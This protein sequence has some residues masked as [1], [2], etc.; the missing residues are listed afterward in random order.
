MQFPPADI[1]S[2]HAVATAL[3]AVAGQSSEGLVLVGSGFD[4]DIWRTGRHTLRL[5]RRT[6]AVALIDNEHRWQ[7]EATAPLR[8]PTPTIVWRGRP[9]ELFPHPWTVTTW[10]DGE[11]ALRTGPITSVDAA[12]VLGEALSDLHRV[13]PHDAPMNPFRGVPLERRTDAF[14][15]NNQRDGDGW[16]LRHFDHARRAPAFSGQPRWLHGDIHGG[17]LLVRDGELTGLIDFGDLC[18]GD[19]ACDLGGALLALHPSTWDVFTTTYRADGPTWQ[20]AFGWL[21]FFIAA[22]LR[23]GGRHAMAADAT[24][25]AWRAL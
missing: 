13:A 24:L 7:A 16:L 8:L 6:S 21:S 3:L 14:V 19:P 25:R 23:I 15:E 9:H 1:E 2:T 4:N 12:R 20:R 10:I 22:H 18:A 11:I 5:P 17:N